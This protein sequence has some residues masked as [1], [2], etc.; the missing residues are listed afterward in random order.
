MGILFVL[1]Y[2]FFSGGQTMMCKVYQSRVRTTLLTYTIYIF[3]NTVSSAIQF[4]FMAGMDLSFNGMTLLLAG[5]AGIITLFNV[6]MPLICMGHTNLAV[7]TVAQNA[8]NLILPSLFGLI[9]LK[10]TISPLQILALV[11]N[12][13]A[14]G[15]SFLHDY[16]ETRKKSSGT[17]DAQEAPSSRPAVGYLAA[18]ALFCTTGSF[19]IVN[20]IF[21]VSS[22]SSSNPAYF[23]WINLFMFPVIVIAFFLQK[24]RARKSFRALTSGIPFKAYSFV[25][26]GS[27]FGAAG[28]IF[29]MQAM[30]LLDMAVYSPVYSSLY[31]LF[32]TMISR[33]VFREKL[34]MINYL[35]ILLSILAVI[36]SVL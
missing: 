27:V 18:V 1:M 25:L 31:M 22:A 34:S 8:G 14:F 10:E 15:I 26:I 7:M 21:T 17:G 6:L 20:K 24:L 35:A 3:A 16:R 33:F 4:F 9:F 19:T 2:V 30:Q 13:A 29:S 11:L 5:I 32:L 28:M 23:C 36:L 12:A